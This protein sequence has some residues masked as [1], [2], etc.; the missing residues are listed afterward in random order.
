MGRRYLV[1][2]G[3]ER[4]QNLSEGEARRERA[5][6]YPSPSTGVRD[7]SSCRFHSKTPNPIFYF[8]SSRK[9]ADA[10]AGAD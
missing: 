6:G 3:R 1:G 5:R 8:R 2:L 4:E 9:K 7:R 10:G